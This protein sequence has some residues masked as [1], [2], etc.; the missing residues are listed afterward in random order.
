MARTTSRSTEVIRD[1]LIAILRSGEQRRP[2]MRGEMSYPMGDRQ[3]TG[4]R[5]LFH[6]QK[7]HLTACGWWGS[8]FGEV[9]IGVDTAW[10]CGH[11]QGQNTPTC[12]S[13]LDHLLSQ[14]GTAEKA[15]LCR[16]CGVIGAARVVETHD[17][18]SPP[19]SSLAPWGGTR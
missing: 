10:P 12:A 8:H 14:G 4:I 1:G 13:H 15:T 7:S 18:P 17:L 11:P 2:A 3:L 6:R 5:R 16:V 9:T 19:T